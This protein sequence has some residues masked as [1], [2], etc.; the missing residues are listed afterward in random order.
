MPINHSVASIREDGLVEKTVVEYPSEGVARVAATFKG[1]MEFSPWSWGH[2]EYKQEFGEIEG[3]PEPEEEVRYVVSAIVLS[4]AKAAG[5]TD[6]VAPAT[7]HPDVVRNDK[8]HI[9]SVPGFVL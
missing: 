3:L 9:V 2:Q 7:G 1:V 4:A 5:R 8:G 6:C